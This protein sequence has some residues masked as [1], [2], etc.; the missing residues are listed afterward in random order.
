MLGVLD[1]ECWSLPLDSGSFQP[2]K[3]KT[4]YNS[5][6]DEQNETT[7]KRIQLPMREGT[8]YI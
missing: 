6:P 2:E 5:G 7:F 3:K 4:F 8:K 1:H